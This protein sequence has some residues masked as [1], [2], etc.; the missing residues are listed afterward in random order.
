MIYTYKCGEL[1][2]TG[3]PFGQFQAI[4]GYNIQGLSPVNEPL[5][6]SEFVNNIACGNMPRS[7]YVNIVY[8]FAGSSGKY[9]FIEK[10]NYSCLFVT[11]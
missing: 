7:P 11:V 2:W 4:V 5:S 8:K 3:P 6:G 1:Q 10:H 9:C